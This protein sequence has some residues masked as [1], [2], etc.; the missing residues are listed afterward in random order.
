MVDLLLLLL[1]W[2]PCP[3]VRRKVG[4]WRSKPFTEAKK[5]LYS[6]PELVID[7]YVVLLLLLHPE[8]PLLLP[9]VNLLPRT[10]PPLPLRFPMPCQV[11]Y[12][13]LSPLHL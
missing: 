10:F 11:N 4:Q 8:S 13:L 2:P 6:V 7:G 1:D 5:T 12:R 9:S 3:D